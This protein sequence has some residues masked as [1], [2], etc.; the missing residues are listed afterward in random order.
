MIRIY[1]VEICYY[2]DLR[3]MGAFHDLG[4]GAGACAGFD[5]F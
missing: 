2:L 5:N 1:F 4:V 3:S